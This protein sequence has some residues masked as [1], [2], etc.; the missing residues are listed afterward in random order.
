MNLA[1][2]QLAAATAVFEGLNGFRNDNDFAT[3]G[4]SG[5]TSGR[6]AKVMLESCLGLCFHAYAPG[7]EY[8]GSGVSARSAAA[9]HNVGR[10]GDG[11]VVRVVQPS[12][13]QR[14]LSG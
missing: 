6:R 12:V 9:V 13:R 4:H 5:I 3:E 1:F 11:P 7:S 14:D 2:P 8:R 10:G